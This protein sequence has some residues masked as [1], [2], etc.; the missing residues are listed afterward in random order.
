M[1][2]GIFSNGF[3]P[4]TTASQHVA[5]KLRDLEPLREPVTAAA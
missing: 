5:P 4:H 3:R 1:E 2:F